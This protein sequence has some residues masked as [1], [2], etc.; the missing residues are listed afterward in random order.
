MTQETQSAARYTSPEVPS[1]LDGRP[2]YWLLSA[3]IIY[4]VYQSHYDVSA[5]IPGLKPM[6]LMFVIAWVSVLLAPEKPKQKAPVRIAFYLLFA[7]TVWGFFIG[8]LQDASQISDELSILKEDLFYPLSY[9]LFFRGVRNIQGVRRIF[10]V[11]LFVGLLVGVQ[12]LREAVDY[13]LTRYNEMRRVAGPFGDSYASNIASAYFAVILPLFVSIALHRKSNKRERMLGIFG[14][15]LTV[16][17]TFF[18]YSRQGYFIESIVLLFMTLRR[19]RLTTLLI[20]GAISTYQLWVPDGVTQ[21]IGM[22]EHVDANGQVT[23]DESTE[24]RFWIWDGA[25]KMIQDHPL[26]V[27]LGNFHRLIHEYAPQIHSL[28]AH[29]F[30]IL[31]SAESGPAALPV[32]LFLLLR[33]LWLARKVEKI[34][35]SEE[36][37]I[38]GQAFTASTLALM[39]VN[40][41]GS[42]LF[43]GDM[44]ISYWVFAGICARY[45]VLKAPSTNNKAAPE[46]RR[47]ENTRMLT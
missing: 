43:N 33:L 40:L 3:F 14:S 31:V 22:T 47:P 17:V 15:A 29:N 21:R 27:G 41:Y 28:D 12:G 20:V 1:R 10:G 44:M 34:D 18:T 23:L 9:F 25:M 39:L 16:F 45:L 2:W 42:R 46:I 6:N 32:V 24:S 38:L 26:G 35:H 8:A 36:T 13:G 5:I 11:L 19:N 37:T 4:G 30:Y 7:A